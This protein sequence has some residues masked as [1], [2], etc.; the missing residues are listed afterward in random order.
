MPIQDTTSA[1]INGKDGTADFTLPSGSSTL[2]YR[3]ILDSMEIREMT[4]L[5]TS[6]T[7][8]IEGTAQQEPGRSQLAFQIGGLGKKGGPASGPLIPAPQAV[9]VVMTFSSSCT[10]SFTAN[11]SEATFTRLVNTNARISGRGVSNGTYA[12]SWHLTTP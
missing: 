1:V 11:F 12:L 3:S 9:A 5:V 8:A 4:E 2:S 6:D 7:F 10:A